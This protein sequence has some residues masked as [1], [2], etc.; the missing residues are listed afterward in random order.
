LPP[1][2][3]IEVDPYP[4]APGADVEVRVLYD[5]GWARGFEIEDVRDGEYQLHRR[6][7]GV[8]LPVRF[9]ANDLRP[10]R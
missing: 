9:R 2:K 10:R 3:P 1:R 8:V 7:D 4:L 6:S 5:G